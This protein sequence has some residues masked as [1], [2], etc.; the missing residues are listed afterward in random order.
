MQK[1]LRWENRV[2][3]TLVA[4]GLALLG[5]FVYLYQSWLYAHTQ[6]SVLDEGSYLVKGFLFATGKYW[7]YQD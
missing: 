1:V 6:N 5:G 2:S 4:E 3:H 7:P